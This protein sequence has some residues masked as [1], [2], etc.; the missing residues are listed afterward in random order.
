V[1]ALLRDPS[2][3]LQYLDMHLSRG[4]S[5]DEDMRTFG[6]QAVSDI[7]ASLVGNTTLKSICIETNDDPFEREYFDSDKLLCDVSSIE[8]ISNSN[9]MLQDVL[10]SGHII[11]TFA[12]RCLLI[13]TVR[14]K[15]KSIRDKILQYY[16]VGEF[17]LSPFVD[18]HLSVLPK[19]WAKLMEMKNNL[20]YI[21][22][23]NVYQSYAVFL[24][25]IHIR[26]WCN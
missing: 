16:F 1:A 21:D 25:H 10:V 15:A 5:D 24:T 2:T 14:D 26:A 12:D 6:E 18:M 22:C 17:D 8:S 9:H 3:V 4:R 11:S 19:S 20:Q 7:W 23:C 13:N